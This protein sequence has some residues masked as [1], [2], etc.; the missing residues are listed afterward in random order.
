MQGTA[1]AY[2]LARFG[3]PTELWIADFDFSKAIRAADRVNGLIG[4][5]IALPAEVDA[6][7]AYALTQ[8]LDRIDIVLSCVPHWM[9][10]LIAPVAI[11]TRTHMCDLGGDDD[12]VEGPLGHDLAARAAGVTIVPDTGLAPGLVNSLARLLMERLD[13]VDTVRLYCG[14]LPLHPEP[15]LY[16]K[17]TFGVEGLVAE[18]DDLAYVLRDGEV[19]QIP[20][21]TELEELEF[22]G[23]GTMEAFVTSGGSGTSPHALRSR[24]RNYEYKTIRFPGHCDKMRLFQEIGLWNTDAIRVDGVSASPRKVFERMLADYLTQFEGPDQ[25]LVR[26]VVI[27]RKDGREVVLQGDVRDIQC[28][29]TGFTSMERLTGYSIAIHAIAI[30]N[31][32]IPVGAIPYDEALSPTRYFHALAR[33]GAQVK[34]KECMESGDSTSTRPILSQ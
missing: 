22:E 34:I 29:E 13:E 24:V 15:P 26:V 19:R 12:V 2:D 1:A 28:P 32:E 30:L 10:P 5:S 7:D 6:T 3:A 16:Y 25:T 8:F 17:L 31:G 33:R 4:R 27:G 20:S 11:K 9:P 18:Y 23:L 21:L 14:V